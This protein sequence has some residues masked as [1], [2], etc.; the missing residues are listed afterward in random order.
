MNNEYQKN[1]QEEEMSFAFDNAMAEL[2]QIFNFDK[3][4]NAII[5]PDVIINLSHCYNLIKMVFEG[6]GAKVS[7]SLYEPH[8]STGCIS[9]R[10]KKIKIYNTD[11]FVKAMRLSSN[12]ETYANA[13]GSTQ[14]NLTFNGLVKYIKD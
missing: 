6:S 14:I 2:G 7:V 12:F 3:L 4:E 1:I 10:G 8:Q 11:K 5:N 9:I 13:D